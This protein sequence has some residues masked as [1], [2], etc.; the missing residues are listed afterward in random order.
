MLVGATASLLS[1][2]SPGGPRLASKEMPVNTRQLLI[3]GAG[4][5]NN[6]FSVKGSYFIIISL[7]NKEQKNILFIG[8]V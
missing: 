3:L 7:I 2:T 4:G 1:L 5:F 6:F 8:A